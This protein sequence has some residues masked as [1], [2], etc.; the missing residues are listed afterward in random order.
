MLSAQ[1]KSVSCLLATVLKEPLRR[2][3]CSQCSSLALFS[4]VLHVRDTI[5]TITSNAPQ[6]LPRM[7]AKLGQIIFISGLSSPRRRRQEEEQS[8]HI[9]EGEERGKLIINAKRKSFPEKLKLF[10]FSSSSLPPLISPSPHP[11]PRSF[12]VIS[13][14]TTIYL[15]PSAPPH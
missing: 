15:A 6:I 11:K 7:S 8:N 1:K 4:V 5:M 13:F 10:V 14:A 12:F 9:S 3:F 2:I